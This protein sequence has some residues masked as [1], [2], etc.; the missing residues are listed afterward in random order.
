M[1][2]LLVISRVSPLYALGNI[3]IR[4]SVLYCLYPVPMSLKNKGGQKVIIDYVNVP[5]QSVFI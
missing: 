5:R 3:N 4:P 2:S 1:Y